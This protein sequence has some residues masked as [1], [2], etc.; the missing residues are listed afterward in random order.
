VTD[1][2]K[3]IILKSSNSTRYR[4]T[5]SNSGLPVF[6]A[7]LWLM[8]ASL[9]PA[10]VIG[11]G[12]ST[13]GTTNNVITDRTG[14]LTWSNA[15]NWNNSTNAAT[16]R[17]NLGLGASDDVTFNS[18]DASVWGYD[19]TPAI[20]V[21]ERTLSDTD[22]NGVLNWG[23][24]EIRIDVPLQFGGPNAASNAATTIGNLFASNSL[25]S[26]AA[27]SNSILT[28]DGSGSSA[29]VASRVVTKFTTTNETKTSWTNNTVTAATNASAQIGTWT[30]DA[31]ATYAV[32]YLVWFASDNTNSAFA[33]SFVMSQPIAPTR[34]MLGVGVSAA[35][36]PVFIG[37][38]F[39]TNT[40]SVSLPVG[41]AA[42][43][44]SNS[45]VTGTFIFRSGTNAGTMA[46]H[47]TAGANVTNA[48][49][50]NAGTTI[51]VE[52]LAP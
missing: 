32:D 49:L 2:T 4:L 52:R 38:S 44:H 27:A 22:G 31:N 13:N 48:L 7:L 5:V 41:I 42:V 16:T 43:G 28:A 9:A 20:S 8:L 17:D 26:G 47:W 1:A 35:A 51:K 12:T 45:I 11:I 25:P 15:F 23:S 21:E 50:L 6:T 18:L 14:T 30:V 36:S 3:G 10:Q 33:A 34:N 40:T 19:G 37:S 24:S 46:F 39:A 29:F